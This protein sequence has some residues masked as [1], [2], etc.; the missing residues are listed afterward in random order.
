[1]KS[2]LYFLLGIVIAAAVVPRIHAEECWPVAV[3]T[4]NWY[5]SMTDRRDL[6]NFATG[7]AAIDALEPWLALHSSNPLGC[8]ITGS[9]GFSQ[10]TTNGCP[11]GI[12]YMTFSTTGQCDGMPQIVYAWYFTNPDDPDCVICDPGCG[13]PVDSDGDGYFDY[14]DLDPLDPNP[15]SWYLLTE[16]KKGEDLVGRTV[17][18]DNGTMMTFGETEADGA[19][20]WVSIGGEWRSQASFIENF[21]LDPCSQPSKTLPGEP[22]YPDTSG[23]PKPPDLPLPGDEQTGGSG[24]T[25]GDFEG[26]S[27]TGGSDTSDLGALNTINTNLGVINENIKGLGAVMDGALDGIATTNANLQSIRGKLDGLQ[28]GMEDALG[29]LGDDLQGAIGGLGTTLGDKIDGLGDTLAG[30]TDPNG[31]AAGEEAWGDPNGQGDFYTETNFK[32]DFD[33]NELAAPEISEQTWLTDFLSSNPL[34]VALTGS[35]FE[36]SGGTC[37]MELDLGSMGVHE[38][39]LCEFEEQFELAGTI[40]YSLCCIASLLLAARGI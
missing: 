26:P 24:G 22:G 36:L 39:S 27:T 12:Y 11:I 6:G 1:M 18:L 33:P 32:T 3:F 30:I 2:I 9:P 17:L 8:N 5:P 21:A 19:T 7:Q 29:G 14:Q 34:G 31:L 40:L 37:T 16:Y 23:I 4:E 20:P 13:D 10:T 38:L 28:E 35:G 15:H 25:P